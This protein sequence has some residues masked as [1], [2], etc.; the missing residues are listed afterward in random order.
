MIIDT[1]VAIVANDRDRI[2]GVG[3]D[4]VLACIAALV[5]ARE[6][7]VILVD[8][9]GL[10]LSEYGRN[11]SFAGQPGAG[12]FFFKWLWNNQANPRYCRR[13]PVTPVE[14]GHS[15]AAPDDP[16]LA[17]FPD[18]P[19]LH[20][21]DRSDRKFVATAIAVGEPA[22]IL[23]ATDTDWQHFRDALHRHGVTVEFICPGFIQRRGTQRKRGRQ[24]GAK[25][26]G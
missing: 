4:C 10:I 3:D 20:G 2:D 18:D 16:P 12:D 22:P 6:N 1:N 26:G 11:L 23:N 8:D 17:E 7:N 9:W 19:A 21:F 13:V 5:S 25:R 14:A 24:R 15:N